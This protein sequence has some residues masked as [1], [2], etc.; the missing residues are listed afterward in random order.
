M[1]KFSIPCDFGGTKAPFEVYIGN[2]KEG[3]HPLQNQSNWLSK[4]RGGSI[5]PKVME[6]F[7][8]L[9][10]LAKKNNV[11]FEELCSYA[12]AAGQEELA[13][14]P[15]QQAA[16]PVQ[17]QPQ[18]VAQ[19]PVQ[20]APLPQ[21]QPIPQVAPQPQ[22]YA[23]PPQPQYAAPPAPQPQAYAPPPQPQA[24][25]PPPQPQYVAPP[26]PQPQAY[27]PPPQPQYV[28]P[29]APQPQAYAPPPPMPQAHT[30]PIPVPPPVILP[31]AGGTIAALPPIQQPSALTPTETPTQNAA[32]GAILPPNPFGNS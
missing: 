15:P 11:S 28:A 27:A 20:A 25:A 3:N 13:K 8:K 16:A 4:E 23:P 17:S 22:A 6:S 29:P 14:M 30:A 10:E 2:P 19:P 31:D 32:P 21:P 7:A 18:P 24:Y 12:L 26:A 1:R 9:L 5:P